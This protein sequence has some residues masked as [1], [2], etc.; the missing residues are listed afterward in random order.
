MLLYNLELSY[1]MTERVMTESSP[2]V[3][4]AAV[5]K[6]HLF[7]LLLIAAVCGGRG[8]RSVVSCSFGKRRRG[9]QVM[10]PDTAIRNLRN[11]AARP[12]LIVKAARALTSMM[13]LPNLKL[14]FS[15]SQKSTVI[16]IQD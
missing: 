8:R 1:N 5:I 14:Q 4:L 16:Y 15:C 11:P 2:Q 6:V 9:E 12:H 10:G 7:P 3:P 13:N